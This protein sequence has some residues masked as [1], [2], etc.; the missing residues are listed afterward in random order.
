M[1]APPRKLLKQENAMSASRPGT[2]RTTISV[3]RR[4]TLRS[5]SSSPALAR[6]PATVTEARWTSPRI[7]TAIASTRTDRM[8]STATSTPLST[9]VTRK[10]TPLVVPTR[11]LARSRNDSGIST[12]TSVA[13]AIERRFPEMTP[14]INSTT[15]IHSSARPGSAKRLWSATRYTASAAR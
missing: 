6:S 1:K 2:P 8:P 13:R 10:D 15:K 11:P 4:S 9:E 3:P 14:D 5:P 12:V 7:I